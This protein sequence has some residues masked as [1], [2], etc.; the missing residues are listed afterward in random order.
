MTNRA[1]PGV[2]LE[3]A[4][5]ESSR[6]EGDTVCLHLTGRWLDPAGAGEEELLVVQVDGRRHRFPARRKLNPKDPQRWSASFRMPAWAEPRHDGQAALWLGTSVIPVP[7]SLAEPNAGAPPVAEPNAGA[8]PV[9]EPHAGAPPVAEPTAGANGQPPGDAL[10]EAPRSGPPADL[11]LNEQVAALHAELAQR[12]AET[13]RVRAQLADAQSELE[14]RVAVQ[15]ALEATHEELR[16]QLQRLTTAVEEQLSRNQAVVERELAEASRLRQDLAATTVA[17]DAAVTEVGGLRS[18][19]DRL[20]AELAATRER[21]SA[22]SGD[23]G[24]ANRLLADARAL[25]EALR[26]DT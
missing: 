7:P 22:E 12:T 14:S 2:P 5:I 21:V 3:L 25:A 4:R 18:Q 15:A 1:A 19:L 13:T 26:G 10:A 8:P 11:Q 23:L 6:A 9:A 20:G 17:R 24:E 16:R